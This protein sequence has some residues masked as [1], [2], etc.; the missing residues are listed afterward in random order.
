MLAGLLVVLAPPA[1]PAAPVP[2]DASALAAVPASAPIV[3]YLHGVE[4]TKDRLVT[5]IKNAVPEVAPLVQAQMEQFLN[6]GIEGRKLRGLAKEGPIF[7]AFLEMPKPGPNPPKMAVLVAATSYIEFRDGVLKEEERKNL[8]SMEGVEKVMADNG[9]TI[10]FVDLK[11]FVA[12]TPDE[13]SA[14]TVARKGPGLNGKISKELADKLM[15][16]DVG[17]YLSMD[18]LNKEYSEQIKQAREGVEQAM[19]LAAEQAGAGQKGMFEMVKGAIGPIFQ[20]IEDSQGLLLTFDFRPS[21]AAMHFQTE[22]RA[23]SSTAK[24]LANVKPASFDDLPKLPAGRMTYSGMAIGSGL[25]KLLGARAGLLLGIG[26]ESDSKEAKEFAGFLTDLGNAKPGVRLDAQSAP[27]AG[28]MVWHYDNPKQAV[29]AILKLVSS[30]QPGST[31]QSSSL[32]QK[33]VV[34]A[35][36]EKYGDISFHHAE[37]VWDI[38]KMVSAGELPEEMK[39]KLAEGMQKLLGPGMKIWFGTDGKALIQVVAKDWAQAQGILDQYMKARQTIGEVA[40]FRDVRKELPAEATILQILDM[41]QYMGVMAD[42][43]MPMIS[44]FVPLPANYPA[45]PAKGVHSFAGMAFTLRAERASVDFF[46]S[47]SAAKGIFEG[48]VKPLRG[49]F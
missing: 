11:G 30:L 49:A 17:A 2:T 35:N 43:V 40:A 48:Y 42:F 10:Y 7:L 26:A 5:M 3:L 21:G 25:F 44:G 28:I 14:K 18:A 31:F 39:K 32:K 15:A 37:V 47:T 12:I 34:K 38:D 29:D 22:F 13:E 19:S 45:P 16:S 27:P 1:L 33:P 9:E 36:A 8:K 24:A 41:V 23:G 6:E 46:L 4:R 20:A